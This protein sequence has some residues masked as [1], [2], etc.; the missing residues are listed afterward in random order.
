M[1]GPGRYLRNMFFFVVIVALVAGA[2]GPSLFA[3]FMGNPGVNG[4]IVG[5][6]LVGMLY[7]FRGV[8]RLKPEIAWIERFRRNQADPSRVPRLIGP[9]ARLLAERK[10]GRVSL[11]AASMRSLLDGIGTRLEETRETARYLIGLLVFLGLLGTFYGLLQTVGAVGGV[12]GALDIGGN[13]NAAQAF[14]NLKQG[15]ESPLGGM[16]TAFSSSLFGLAGSL[17]LGFLDLQAGLAQNRFYNDLEEWLSGITRMTSAGGALA[18]VGDAPVPAYIQALLEQ[19]ADSL[20]GLQ[21][22]LGR[23]EESRIVAN[24]N[25]VSLTEKLG[26]LTD[27]MRTEQS[28]LA[29]LAESQ[30]ELRP[31]LQRLADATQGAAAQ[32][33]TRSHLRNIELHLARLYEDV[34]QGRGTAVQE[35]RNEIRLLARTIAALAEETER[36]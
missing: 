6:V 17:V 19:T 14:N 30:T 28:L 25:V 21:R 4:V 24:A 20:D 3:Y 7:I 9:L 29:K 22:I 26:N 33:E 2:L 32:E 1:T 8:F 27:H 15:L 35:I 12:L 10:S 11:T 13:D 23:G 34:S 18:E 5:I 16:S 31:V 36:R